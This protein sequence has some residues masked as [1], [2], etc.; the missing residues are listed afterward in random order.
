MLRFYFEKLVGYDGLNLLT[1]REQNG[2]NPRV[3]VSPIASTMLRQVKSN[4]VLNKPYPQIVDIKYAPT[5]GNFK[6]IMPISVGPAPWLWSGPDSKGN[7]GNPENPNHKN[8]FSF[9]NPSML[10]LL[11]NK[12]GFFLID[13]THEGY[14]APW[15]FD[16][17]HTS[18]QDYGI[19]P[20]QIMYFT[21]DIEAEERYR[22]W[23]EAHN[24][25][26]DML[27]VGW[28]HFEFAIYEVSRGYTEFGLPHPGKIVMRKLPDFD[29]QMAFKKF[30]PPAIQTF[31]ILQKRTRPHRL[32]FYKYLHD[33]DLIRDNLVSM[34]KF[35]WQES[36]N[37]GKSISPEDAERL[38]LT[39][40]LMP[41]ENPENYGRSNFESGDGG[42]YIS[43]I[44]DITTLKTWCSVVSEASCSDAEGTC[45][46]SEKTFKPIACQHPFIILGSKGVLKNL[47][48]LGYK[49]FYPYINEGYDE[50]PTFERM[51]YIVKEM[52][53]IQSF[54]IEEKFKWYY[55]IEGILKYNF[56]HF[57]NRAETYVFDLYEIMINHINKNASRHT[58]N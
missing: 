25:P 22:Q 34:N 4:P 35:T 39:L 58:E 21:G 26:P 14:H 40:P 46:I 10:E 42:A 43:K 19:P 3:G 30:N 50:L 29:Y 1:C 45:F 2:L 7:G 9:I 15:L 36:Y 18:C 53:R 52:R 44:S 11:R 55:D 27:V 33:A 5:Y 23:A 41:F 24:V 56:R 51:E 13:Q 54:S 49:T 20:S 47:R 17:F 32:W 31:N 38:N 6:F 16:W 28:P 8:L 48:K 57:Q 12:Q 37:E